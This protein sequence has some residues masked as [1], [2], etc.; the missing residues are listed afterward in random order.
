VKL[1]LAWKGVSYPEHTP[2]YRLGFNA[3]DLNQKIAQA[4]R[5]AGAS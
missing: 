2:S 4:L 5:L 3:D 1:V